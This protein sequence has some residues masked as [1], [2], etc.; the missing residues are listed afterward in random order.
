MQYRGKVIRTLIGRRCDLKYMIVLLLA[1]AAIPSLGQ[2]LDRGLEGSEN[3]MPDCGAWS[4]ES[5]C[6]EEYESPLDDVLEVFIF[7]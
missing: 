3:T 1:V 5:G 6:E 4:G 2:K 7:H